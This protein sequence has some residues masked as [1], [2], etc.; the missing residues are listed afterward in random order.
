M[1]AAARAAADP[2]AARGGRQ[3]LLWLDGRARG[4]GVVAFSRRAPFSAQ[5]L[6]GQRPRV[7]ARAPEAPLV[8]PGVRSPRSSGASTG[9]AFSS[10]H[11]QVPESVHAARRAHNEH[12]FHAYRVILLP[13]LASKQNTE[14]VNKQSAKTLGC[15][16]CALGK[17]PT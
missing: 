17:M 15:R 1:V 6:V 16:T 3:R 7:A 8:L 9:Y 11:A 10:L 2:R 12:A 14:H 5:A 13:H 4:G